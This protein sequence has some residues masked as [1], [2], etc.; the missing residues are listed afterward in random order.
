MRAQSSHPST[1]SA[2]ADIAAVLRLIAD[3]RRT[4]AASLLEAEEAAGPADALAWSQLG[5]AWLQAGR[6]VDAER[7]YARAEATSPG[8]TSLIYNLA[9][10]KVATGDITGAEGLFDQV[11]ERDPA[12][13]DAWQNRSTLRRW[14]AD[15]NHIDALQRAAATYAG[16]PEAIALAYALA[17]ELED[18]GRPDE[19]F[20]WLEKGAALRRAR[21]RYEVEQD[22]A[23]MRELTRA[24]TVGTL[25]SARRS[26]RPGPIFVMGL[27]RSGTT[28]V[29]R[30]LSSHPEVES[31]GEIPDFALSLIK[32]L[33]PGGGKLDLIQAST[34]MDHRALGETYRDRL[35]GFGAEAPYLI[36]KTPHNY[37]YVGLIALALPE[38]R[39]VYVRRDPR[40]VGYALYK[41]LFRTGCP[42]SYDLDDLGRYIAG[43]LDLM[44]HWRSALPGRMV[45]ID[46]EALTAAAEPES[47][48]LLEALG[49]AWDPV[50]LDFH[51][52]EAP[53]ATASAAQVREPI[54]QRSI[55]LWRAHERGLAPML[56]HLD[57]FAA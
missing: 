31:L 33:S 34:R 44:A 17:K 14:T 50:C 51:T 25:S 19:A 48:R 15:D 38:A 30:I 46:Y 20:A 32:S 22:L 3:G 18:V 2:P 10:A 1:P 27:P 35:Q 40:D 7:C 24:F 6:F 37:L 57:R 39:I 26:N 5:E 42:Y 29:D 52:L 13:A 53:A 45:E 8:D 4:V 16:P 47:R 43:Q 9:A 54:H 23:V 11:I 55:G 28:L 36:D 49:L 41:T 12:N 56:R 21:L